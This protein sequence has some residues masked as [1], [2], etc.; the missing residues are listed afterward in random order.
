MSE[1]LVTNMSYGYL[2]IN[3]KKANHVPYLEEN[4]DAVDEKKDDHNE[5]EA[6]ITTVENVGIV[7]NVLK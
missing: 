2:K 4:F 6:G 1:G 7:L 3:Q 5:H